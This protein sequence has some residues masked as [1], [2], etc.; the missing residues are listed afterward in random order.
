MSLYDYLQGQKISGEDYPFYALVQACMRQ[1]D[2][3]NLEKLK[4]IFPE[5]WKELQARYNA[6]GGKLEGEE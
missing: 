5:V 4:M 1:A 3:N 6:L 2:T